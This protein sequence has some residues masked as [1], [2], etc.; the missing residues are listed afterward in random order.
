MLGAHFMTLTAHPSRD[1]LEENFQKFPRNKNK[2]PQQN[3]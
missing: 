1:C 2:K 3:K